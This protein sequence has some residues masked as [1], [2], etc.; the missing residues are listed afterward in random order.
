MSREERK[1]QREQRGLLKHKDFEQIK[2]DLINNKKSI[3][4]IAETYG[5]HRNTLSNYKNKHLLPEAAKRRRYLQTRD[6]ESV[7]NQVQRLVNTAQDM[8][9]S[10]AEYLADPEDP[11][12]FIVAPTAPEIQV[13]YWTHNPDTGENE[14]HRGSLQEL[15][16]EAAEKTGAGFQVE[17]L[18]SNSPDPRKLLLEAIERTEKILK[19][20]AQIEGS[21]EKGD[22]HYH[23]TM[24]P[25][26]QQ[27]QRVILQATEAYPEARERI[28]VQ[29]RQLSQSQ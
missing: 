2:R 8:V 3:G 5:V 9:D 17:R 13:L 27:I 10:C 21:I 15:L 16:D 1:Q 29:L 22:K 6:G 23:I 28:R 24:L 20:M 7:L 26:W 18:H 19:L 14:R 4:E 12:R 11:E 25:E